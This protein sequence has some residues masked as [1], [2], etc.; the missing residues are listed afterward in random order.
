MNKKQFLILLVVVA[1][2][3]IWGWN[4]WKNQNAAWNGGGP[5]AGQKLLKDFDVNA[6]AQLALRHGTNEVL[7]ARQDKVWRV[8]QR[9][10]Y[11]AS[12]SEISSLLIKLKDLKAV[13]VEQV[14]ASQLSRLELAP[15]GTNEPTVVDF[16]DANGKSLESLTLGKTLMDQSSDNSMMNDFGGGGFPKGRYA[17]TGAAKDSVAVISDPLSDVTADA[18]HWLD[19]TFFRVEKPKQISVTFPEAT[20]SWTLTRESETSEWK[21]ADL[22]EGEKLDTSKSSSV[23]YPFSSPSFTDVVL[24]LTPEQSGLDQPTVIR[25]ATFDGF[26]YTVNVGTKTNEHFLLTV[27]VTG[28]FPK[29]RTAGADEKPEDKAKADKEF[30]E[31]LEKRRE[32]LTKEKT[33]APWTYQVTT[34]TVESL[35]KKRSELLEHKSDDHESNDV[36]APGA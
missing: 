23:T 2:L 9:H 31:Q 34:W 12:F 11:P 26:D 18:G 8:A 20:N 3:A 21:L 32:K 5:A 36:A 25:I 29:E 28:N 13:Q 15:S 6:V 33:F 7:L 17:Q 4:R 27:A 1:V 19:K 22:K 16:R 10:D 24:N 30:S 14:G 35:L